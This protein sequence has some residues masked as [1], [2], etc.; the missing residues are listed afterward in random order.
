MTIWILC[1]S[2]LLVKTIRI[3]RAFQG[4]IVAQNVKPFIA[5]ASTQRAL[6]ASL[7]AVQMSLTIT[8]LTLGPP[9]KETT[10]T[11]LKHISIICK[12]HSSVTGKNIV[13]ANI[14]YGFVLSLS[15]AYYAYKVRNIPENF[16]EAKRIGFAMYILLL[17]ALAYY[18]V[19]FALDGWHITVLECA[20]NIT[21]ALGFLL[22]IFAPRIYIILFKPGQNTLVVSRAQVASY[23]FA[24]TTHHVAFTN[25]GRLTNTTKT[26]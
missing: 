9:Y 4:N 13:L 23:S 14:T 3:A 11:Y 15:C 18:P 12:A 25:G 1:V 2:V 26:L 20:T 17:S 21:S 8:W 16:N 19:A 10:I 22:C 6:L 5:K 24:T 7:T